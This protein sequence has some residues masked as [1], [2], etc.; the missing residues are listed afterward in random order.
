MYDEMDRK[1]RS[2]EVGREGG[3]REGRRRREEEYCFVFSESDHGSGFRSFI[4]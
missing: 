1:G 2:R 3:G 4:G